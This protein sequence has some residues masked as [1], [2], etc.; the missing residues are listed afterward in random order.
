MQTQKPTADD[1]S[2]KNKQVSEDVPSNDELP[3]L[4]FP[5][6]GKLK[7]SSR[8]IHQK[9][10]YGYFA[11]IGIGFL[12]SLV[13]LVIANYYRGREIRQFNHAK[14]QTQMLSHYKDATQEVKLHSYSLAAA[15]GQPQQLSRK[16]ANFRESLDKVKDVEVKISEFII[17]KPDG[18]AATE[19]TLQS[20]LQNYDISLES[21]TQKLN[22]ILSQIDEQPQPEQLSAVQQQLLELTRSQT[23]IRL[24]QLGK[25][26]NNILQSAEVEESKRAKDLEFSKGIE[27]TIVIASMLLSVAIAVV[28]AWRTSRAIAEP[29]VVVTQVAEQVARKSNFDLRAPVTTED[30]IGLLAKSLNRLIERVSQRTKDLENAKELAEAA[31]KA[32][33]QFLANVSHELRTPLNAIIGLS[34]LLQEDAADLGVAGE[35][36]TDLETINTAGKHLLELINDILDLSKNRS[37]ENDS[38]SGEI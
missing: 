8:R 19:A 17:S 33:S 31:S 20:L 16:K 27:R 35:F 5:S 3:T 30:E 23:A 24:E 2:S 21:Y 7:A 11:A 13:G 4:E 29:V 38:L 10:G 15:I 25:R 22:L 9:I 32:K 18:L 37:R 6:S 34:Q 26:L 1:S 14:Y 28:V 36:T 12:G